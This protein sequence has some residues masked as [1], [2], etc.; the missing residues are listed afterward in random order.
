[1]YNSNFS[2]P[3]FGLEV[4][5]IQKSN[6][7]S[8]GY[9]LRIIFFFSSLIQSLII[10]SL[11][12]FLVYG[13]PEQS[14]EGK[15]VQDLEH[16]LKQVNS[17]NQVLKQQEK[18]FTE[19]LEKKNAEKVSNEQHLKDLNIFT[20]CSLLQNQCELDKKKAE[21]RCSVPVK[22]PSQVP[23]INPATS[24]SYGV[25]IW[26]SNFT[27]TTQELKSKMEDTTKTLD[28]LQL[29]KQNAEEQ[30][31]TYTKLCKED[32]TTPLKGIQDV[33]RAFLTKIDNLFLPTTFPL[34]CENQ[35]KQIEKVR[36]S[37]TNLS[38]DIEEKFQNY[39]DNVG[40]KV[41]NIQDERSKLMAENAQLAE[42]VKQCPQKRVG[43]AVPPDTPPQDNGTERKEGWQNPEN[44]EVL[45]EEKDNM[46]NM[47][48][49]NI[50][51]PGWTPS[52]FQVNNYKHVNKYGRFKTAE[53]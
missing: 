41:T 32:F 29:E 28:R 43:R 24:K 21:L 50:M 44:Q 20:A 22:C 33:T 3:A 12:L 36:S 38:K 40:E 30:L 4:K 5:D 46:L 2:R 7:K 11:V 10:V 9:Y 18:N 25:F 6:G 19:V 49:R 26:V 37:C 31:R 14:V 51:G 52:D 45:L 15:R 17:E 34:S 39:L 1:M 27:R 47:S 42:S 13:Q 48:K 35:Q 53:Y 16:S 23:V 8:C